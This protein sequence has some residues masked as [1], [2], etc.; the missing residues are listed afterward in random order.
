MLRMHL[1]EEED[2]LMN[3]ENQLLIQIHIKRLM[4]QKKHQKSR[5]SVS[6]NL[7]SKSLNRIA[8]IGE[9]KDKKMLPRKLRM[10]LLKQ[11]KKRMLRLLPSRISLRNKMQ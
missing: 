10:Q 8:K 2:L 11:R 7:C 6:V 1:N 9:R 5:K 4:D 3:Q